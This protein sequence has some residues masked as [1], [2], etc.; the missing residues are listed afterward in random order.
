MSPFAGP[1]V[2]SSAPKNPSTGVAS[3]ASMPMK[4]PRPVGRVSARLVSEV[5]ERLSARDHELLALVAR[6]RVM[7]GAQL[8]EL[9]WPE[10]TPATRARLARRGLARLADL[11]VLERLPRRVGG[12][13]AG[14]SGLVFAPG[15]VGLRLLQQSASHRRVRRAYA[16][17]ERYLAH[18]LAVGQL[19]VDL[20]RATRWGLAELLAF[21]PEPTC[22]RRY[23][24]PYGA[25]LTLKPDA[26]VRLGVGDYELSWFIETD[27][28][29][30]APVTLLG[31]ARRYIDYWHTGTEQTARDIFPHVA[32]IAPH[33]ARAEVIAEALAGLP[34]PELFA[35]TTA[36][37]AVSLLTTESNS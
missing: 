33:A 37:E 24:S 36:H 23:S 17:G 2:S 1:L 21:D 11:T 6:F 18:A 30:E 7:S 5:A 15:R 26:Y 13:R 22:W 19:Y 34:H 35:T 20:I 28:A 29:S 10:G 32:W 9:F 4:D 8:R 27:M 25:R 14:S 31:K 16:P 3:S 12:V